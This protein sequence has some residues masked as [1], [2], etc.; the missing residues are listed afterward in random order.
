MPPENI[1]RISVFGLG[2]RFLSGTRNSHFS[3]PV[4]SAILYCSVSPELALWGERSP[5]YRKY[6]ASGIVRRSTSHKAVLNLRYTIF[7]PSRE[8][9]RQ[10]LFLLHNGYTFLLPY[11]TV[12]PIEDIHSLFRC[13]FHQLSSYISGYTRSSWS[14]CTEVRNVNLLSDSPD[15]P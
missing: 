11:P 3:R 12:R 2:H 6:S 1:R 15:L 13:Y 4:T 5:L 8:K 9:K 14:Q 7:S 10:I